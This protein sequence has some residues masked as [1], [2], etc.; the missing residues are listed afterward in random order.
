[1]ALHFDDVAEGERVFGA[2]APNGKVQMP[3]QPTF[4]AKG[5]GM[6]IDQFGTPWIINAGQQIGV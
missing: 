1:V 6:L 5:F 3:Y 2:L 4:W